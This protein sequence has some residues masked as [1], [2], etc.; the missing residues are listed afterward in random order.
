[1]P[2]SVYALNFMKISSEILPNPCPL[3]H[4]IDPEDLD[5]ERLRASEEWVV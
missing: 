5:M 3:Q 1:M 4:F 2:K